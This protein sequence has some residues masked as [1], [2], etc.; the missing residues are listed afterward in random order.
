MDLVADAAKDDQ[1]RFFIAGRMGRVI[2]S[3]MVAPHLPR[4]HRT[5]LVGVAAY[6]DDGVH[7]LVQ[8]VIHV[9]RGVRADIDADFGH[10]FDG[11]RVNIARGIRSGAM[12]IE[13]VTGGLS[14]Q[15]FGHVATAGVSG[16]E[17]ENER[18]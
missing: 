16:A 1:L 13:Q 6:G 5:G 3:P 15:A 18:L 8:K 14:K 9:L 17:N 11:E 10:G 2:E 4:I 7:I 12:D